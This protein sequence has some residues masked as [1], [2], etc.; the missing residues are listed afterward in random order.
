MKPKLMAVKDHAL[1]KKRMFIECCFDILVHSM[2]IRHSRYRSVKSMI[3]TV[4]S[5]LIAYS[6]LD[7]KPSTAI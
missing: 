6:Y 4:F 2:V 3:A 1:L 5:C 7:K